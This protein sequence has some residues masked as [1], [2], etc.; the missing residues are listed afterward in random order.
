MKKAIIAGSNGQDGRLLTDL[1]LKKGYDLLGIHKKGLSGAKPSSIE[2]IDISDPAQ[3]ERIAKV[4]QP[5]EIYYL[6][7]FHHSSQDK[8]PDN[9][10]LFE[11]SF[12]V[13]T[14]GFVYFLEAVRSVCPGA[15]LMY[16]ASSKIFGEPETDIQTELT[17]MN[18]VCV[19]GMSKAAGVSAC[20]HYRLVHKIFASAAILYNH[21]SSLRDE[22]FLSRKI[23]KSAIAIKSGRQS[24]LELGDLDAEVDWGYAPDYVEAMFRIV[25]M[26]NPED[27]IVATGEKHSVR[28]FAEAVFRALGMDWKQYVKEIKGVVSRSP[29]ALVGDPSRL[30]LLTGWRPS[31]DFAGMIYRLLEEEGVLAHGK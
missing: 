14:F 5:A 19:Y 1:L 26:Q 28:E 15:R 27:L 22:K 12:Q 31:I 29:R 3:V 24:N 25:Q 4:F 20:R 6:A 18:P 17:P 30:K 7:A 9:V 23:I 10:E 8:V 16:A 21:E 13:N 2:S 11:K